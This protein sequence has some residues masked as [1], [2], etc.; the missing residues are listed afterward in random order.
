M[1]DRSPVTSHEGV[2]AAK[3]LSARTRLCV[4][5]RMP[6][7]FPIAVGIGRVI[8]RCLGLNRPSALGTPKDT[9]RFILSNKFKLIE[10]IS[11]ALV[12][13]SRRKISG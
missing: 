7:L 8:N 4:A 2:V 12:E 6:G 1:P 5:V 11:E 9:D 3:H 13:K 10:C